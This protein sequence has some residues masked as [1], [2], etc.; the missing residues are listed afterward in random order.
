MIYNYK[1][2]KAIEKEM[3][4]DCR[5]TTKQIV[6]FLRNYFQRSGHNKA[7]VGLS[8][9]LDSSVTTALCVNALG[10]KNVVVVLLPYEGITSSRSKLD[11]YQVIKKFNLSNNV[12]AIGIKEAVDVFA[13]Q[14]PDR[15]IY[16]VFLKFII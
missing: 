12:S 1:K 13:K 15:I 3:R 5:N 7:V 4:I 11:A 6:S 8:G 14:R 2:H 16:P 9:G 10:S